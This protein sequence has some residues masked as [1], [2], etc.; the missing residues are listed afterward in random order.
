MNPKLDMALLFIGGL[1]MVAIA[2]LF[3]EAQL[4]IAVLATIAFVYMALKY[5]AL[6]EK[7]M[8]KPAPKEEPKK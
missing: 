3:A 7:N 1:T 6:K 4:L 8:P 5:D 2:L